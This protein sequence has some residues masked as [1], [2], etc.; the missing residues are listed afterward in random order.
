MDAAV[1]YFTTIMFWATCDQEFEYLYSEQTILDPPVWKVRD[2]TWW[3]LTF[4]PLNTLV[5][6]SA[7]WASI[8]RTHQM[9][10]STITYLSKLIVESALHLAAKP[11]TSGQYLRAQY[12]M[13]Q[14]SRLAKLYV[15]PSKI[16]AQIE[17]AKLA[18]NTIFHHFG[19]PISP[20]VSMTPVPMLWI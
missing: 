18:F 7:Q 10:M 16:D 20:G 15:I 5:S 17:T 14:I 19:S 8:T 6:D 1:R 2:T 11:K 12:R 3:S 4:S 9:T 13:W